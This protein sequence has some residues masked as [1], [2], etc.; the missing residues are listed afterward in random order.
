MWVWITGSLLQ[1]CPTKIFQSFPPCTSTHTKIFQLWGVLLELG[2][3]ILWGFLIRRYTFCW[4]FQ[5]GSS[6]HF[7]FHRKAA[8]VTHKTNAARDDLVQTR[9]SDL[10]WQEGVKPPFTHL[11]TDESHSNITP[12]PAHFFK[13]Y[14]IYSILC[15]VSGANH[16]Y[17]GSNPKY[18]TFCQQAKTKSQ[19][20][21]VTFTL[22]YCNSPYLNVK[23]T[24]NV[25]M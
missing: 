6:F 23:N 14:L 8:T 12:S 17:C 3:W 11:P 10:Y 19:N 13:I 18:L 24:I 9:P 7:L 4:Y 1:Q 25:L 5:T 2:V 20:P 21:S 15:L 22:I 16:P